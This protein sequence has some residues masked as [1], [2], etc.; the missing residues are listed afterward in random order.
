MKRNPGKL[1]PAVAADLFCL[2]TPGV[3]AIPNR[4]R[5]GCEEM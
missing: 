1:D 5:I 4:Q 3:D 2:P